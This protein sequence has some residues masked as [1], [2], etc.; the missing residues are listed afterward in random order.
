MI[1]ISKVCF[2]FAICAISVSLFS[3]GGDDAEPQV[4]PSDK[5]I[6]KF[7]LKAFNP[8]IEGLISHEN[9][10]IKF[11]LPMGTTN[12]EYAPTI[13]L[14]SG[15]TVSPAS[16]VSQDFSEPVVY[17]VSGHDG[18][19]KYTVTAEVSETA[20]FTANFFSEKSYQYNG[21]VSITGGDFT[22]LDEGFIVLKNVSTNTTYEI[23]IDL[24][25]S[26]DLSIRGIIDGLPLGTYSGV[27]HLGNQW[28]EI[29]GTIDIVRNP[30]IIDGYSKST[31]AAGENLI[32]EGQYFAPTTQ[33]VELKPLSGTEPYPQA[34]IV[35]ES[36]T[37]IEIRIPEGVTLGNYYIQIKYPA[38]GLTY[39]AVGAQIEVV[40][41]SNLPQI[42]SVNK[43]TFQRGEVI[44]I[45]GKNLKKAGVATNINFMPAAGGT[46]IVRSAVA[47]ADG[48]QVTYTIPNDFPVNTYV[49]AVEVDFEYSN[50]YAQNIQINP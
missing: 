6:K 17:T 47:T 37:T 5:T 49:I 10:T 40:A 27:L 31:V 19:K 33:T 23:D 25:Q 9:G 24:A 3:C 16:D 8:A 34:V 42:T 35:S 43:T 15:V 12:M 26:G 21:F 2:L 36:T 32:I 13:T 39:T 7:E 48:T 4:R 38:N 44:T 28:T 18:T 22:D 50:D 20:S 14:G 45:T 1:K 11:T 30:L 29:T 46:T 41:P